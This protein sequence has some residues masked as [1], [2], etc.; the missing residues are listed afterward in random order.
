[1]TA[2]Y[3]A[4]ALGGRKSGSGWMARCPAH[5]DINPSLSLRDTN[6]KILVYCFAGCSQR[7]VISALREL[8]LWPEIPQKHWTQTEKQDYSRRRSRAEESAKRALFW[9][10]AIVRELERV[11]AATYARYLAHPDENTERAWSDASRRLY[12]AEQL[13]GAALAGEYRKLLGRDPA[14][15]RELISKAREDLAHAE[16]CADLLVTALNGR[17]GNGR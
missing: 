16:R 10:G 15:L 1:M 8:G 4:K 9:R 17:V 3:I 14:A 13:R 7:D 11:Q 12:L 6:G 5:R 2:A